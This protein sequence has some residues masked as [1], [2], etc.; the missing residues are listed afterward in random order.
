MWFPPKD[1]DHRVTTA[2]SG[3]RFSQYCLFY[4]YATLTLVSNEILPV[5][6]TELFV[7]SLLVFITMFLMGMVI[8]EIASILSA[9]T[10]K[11][12]EKNEELGIIETILVDLRIEQHIQNRVFEYY[13]KFKESKYVNTPQVSDLMSPNLAGL[14]KI[15][16]IEETITK[17]SFLDC[18]SVIQIT[19]F[20]NEL[21]VQFYLAGDIVL[22]Q[23]MGS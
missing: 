20:V 7:A 13:E 19:K 15:F 6:R 16:Q 12:R 10:K 3:N 17:L 23:G 11:E 2:Y 5:T 22:K 14:G 9:M 21:Q 18:K 8:G 4:Y 1:L